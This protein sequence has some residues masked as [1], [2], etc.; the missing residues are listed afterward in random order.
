M[1]EVKIREIPFLKVQSCIITVKNEKNRAFLGIFLLIQKTVLCL[2]GPAAARNVGQ[3]AKK[4]LYKL[5]L[6]MEVYNALAS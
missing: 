6:N 4:D 3:E 5:Q 1:Q 2:N